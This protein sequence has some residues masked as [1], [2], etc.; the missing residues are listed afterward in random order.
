MVSV[1]REV[2]TEIPVDRQE[3][4]MKCENCDKELP[5]DNWVF[6]DKIRRFFETFASRATGKR[7]FCSED[8]M[9][10]K[11]AEEHEQRRANR[12]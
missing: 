8:C 4:F 3:D 11:Q 2:K 6:A 9:R 7:I 10:A 1:G 5:V 12:P